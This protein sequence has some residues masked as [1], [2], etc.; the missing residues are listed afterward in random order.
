VVLST[1]KGVLHLHHHR[2]AHKVNIPGQGQHHREGQRSARIR[3]G[4]EG[5]EQRRKD[6]IW[7]TKEQNVASF[8]SLQIVAARSFP[9]FFLA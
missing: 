8:S 4:R 7:R 2:D 3:G 1:S 5:W 9:L 6:K